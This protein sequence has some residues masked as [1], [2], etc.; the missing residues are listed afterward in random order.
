VK[1]A[2]RLRS[3]RG[4]SGQGKF[5]ID[6]I[7][8]IERAAET[9]ICFETLFLCAE[10]PGEPLYR[11]ARTLADGGAE[12][13]EVTP[14]V[15][16]KLAYGN[17]RQGVVAVARTPRTRL[18]DL[19]PAA[20]GPVVVLEGIEKPGNVGAVLRSA[21]AAGAA[22]VVVA[23]GVTDLYNPNA[24]RASLGAIFSV[25]VCTAGSAQTLDWLRETRRCVYATRVGGREVYTGVPLDIPCAVVLGSE[26]RGLSDVWR[27]PDI[28]EIALP[29]LG[30][31]DSLNV[32]V[33][34]AVLLYEALRQRARREP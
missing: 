30:I 23:D 20:A 17:R 32:S 29:M 15:F 2:A 16:E 13:L 8:E 31:A 3:R 28:T 27:G 19:R 18:E 22:A 21:D 4:R 12:V 6:G 25:P 33:T 26:S 7:R 10:R 9:G 14:V 34:A 5:V 24:I 11:L 1:N